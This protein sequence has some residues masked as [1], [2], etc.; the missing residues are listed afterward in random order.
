MGASEAERDKKYSQ[1]TAGKSRL[2]RLLI[3]NWEPRNRAPEATRPGLPEVEID[4][5]LTKHPTLHNI[6]SRMILSQADAN[7][8]AKIK[9]GA[10]AIESLL[11]APSAEVA[12]GALV[13][14]RC[15]VQ[16]GGGE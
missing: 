1:F 5:A 7:F 15:R 10:Q 3:D 12:A 9:F 16:G 4:K 2:L 8:F 13:S 11:R 6:G 14:T